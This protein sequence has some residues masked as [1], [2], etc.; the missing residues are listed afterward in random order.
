MRPSAGAASVALCPEGPPVN[1]PVDVPLTGSPCNRILDNLPVAM[2]RWRLDGER[3]F[4]MYERGF[5]VG[6]KAAREV[7]AHSASVDT[8]MFSAAKS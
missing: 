8:A 7:R 6:F 5:P 4:K 2:V 3:E 1:T